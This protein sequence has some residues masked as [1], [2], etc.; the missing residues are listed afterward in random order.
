MDQEVLPEEEHAAKVIFK[1]I[2]GP[3]FKMTLPSYQKFWVV[4]MT[5]ACGKRGAGRCS[6][7]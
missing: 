6:K 4:G 3:F 2:E 1:V 5:G 7:L